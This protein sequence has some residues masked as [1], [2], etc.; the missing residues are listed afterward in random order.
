MQVLYETDCL[1]GNFSEKTENVRT[2]DLCCGR[3]LLTTESLIVK[4]LSCV[5][6][7]RV[8]G[9]SMIAEERRQ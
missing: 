5:G 4:A 3:F 8:P 9:P 7:I 2:K 1:T 6:R